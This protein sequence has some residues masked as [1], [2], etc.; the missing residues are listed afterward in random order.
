[1]TDQLTAAPIIL[2]R[3]PITVEAMKVEANNLYLVATWCG[4][5]VATNAG[6]WV[7]MDTGDPGFAHIG[8][9]IVRGSSGFYPATD[10]ALWA[11]YEAVLPGAP[12]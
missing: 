7:V 6:V 3:R 11:G 1:V 12:E 10:E 4:G 8:Q 2:R 9:W 5:T